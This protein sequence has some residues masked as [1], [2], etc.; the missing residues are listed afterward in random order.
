M[1]KIIFKYAL[2]LGIDGVKCPYRPGVIMMNDLILSYRY[3]F[4][5]Y[6]VEGS[7]LSINPVY[8]SAELGE[9]HSFNVND[10]SEELFAGSLHE[11]VDWCAKNHKKFPIGV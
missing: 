1:G 10:L 6:A 2:L 4:N 7:M 11:C 3:Q 5:S 9:I 8:A